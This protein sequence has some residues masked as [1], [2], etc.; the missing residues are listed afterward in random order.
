[1]KRNKAT[2][3]YK[4]II[5]GKGPIEYDFYLNKYNLYKCIYKNN[6]CVVSLFFRTFQIGKDF[7]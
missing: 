5:N 4:F 2:T 3:V 1:M 7:Q 6:S